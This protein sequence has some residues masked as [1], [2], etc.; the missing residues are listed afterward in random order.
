MKSGVNR[1]KRLCGRILAAAVA[2][3][4]SLAVGC[5]KTYEMDLPLAVTANTLKLTKDAGSTHILI[6]AADKWTATLTDEVKWASINKLSG[7]GNA[8]IV[9]AYAANYGVSR[10]VGVVFTAGGLRDTVMLTQAAAV[11]EPAINFTDRSA[12]LLGA[13]STVRI[14]LTTNVQYNVDDMRVRVT[15]EGEDD[16]EGQS[17]QA[18][19]WISDITFDAESLSL[20]APDYAGDMPRIG[21]VTLSLTDADGESTTTMLTVTQTR[22][23]PQLELSSDAY[24]YD[25]FAQSYAIPAETNLLSYAD[26]IEFTVDYD[27]PV[28]EGEEWVRGLRLTGDGLQFTLAANEEAVRTATLSIAFTDSQGGSVTAEHRITQ[29]IYPKLLAF[30]DLRA[31]IGGASGEAEISVENAIEG[32]V[33]SDPASANVCIS[34][35]TAQFKFDVEESY[36][37]A[38]VE[39]TDGRYGF[40][41]KFASAKDNVLERYSKVR[42]ALK[43][44]TLAKEADPA[45]YTLKGLKAESVIEAAAPDAG[46]LPVKE[47]TIAQLGDDDIFTQVALQDV[48]I[49][50]KDG[51]FTNCTDGYALKT[52]EMNPAGTTTAPRWDCAPLLMTDNTGRAIYMLTN[53]MVPWRRDGRGVPQGA[54]TFNGVVVAEELVRYGD[55]GRYQIRAMTR[56]DIALGDVPA[57]TTLVEWNWSDSKNDVI[58]EVGTGSI[59][60]YDATTALCSDFNAL[61]HYNVPSSPTEVSTDTNAN[62]TGKGLVNNR[63]VYVN[64]RWWDFDANTGRYFDVKFSTAGVSGTNLAIGFAWNHGKMGNTTL[65]SPAHWK[66]L[67]SIDGGETFS[68]F[69]PLVENRSITWWTTTSQDSC[70]GFKDFM[71]PLPAECFGRAEVIVR[72]QVADKVTDIAPG[73]SASTFLQNLGIGRGTLTDKET[74]IRFGALAVRYN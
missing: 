53:S 61:V 54:G 62:N 25:G 9:F 21:Y 72:F 74:Q 51:C 63:A 71:F 47:R 20:S 38:Y 14:P 19:G 31:M 6:Y 59:E 37:T 45:R 23:G 67:Y 40:C 15:Y 11:A 39:S 33:V 30:A 60:L 16:D 52:A 46:Q 18:E 41:L 55:L 58:P 73:T 27:T 64:N 13:A 35:Q 43:G 70:P 56:E 17:A 10:K 4:V 7:E 32:F 2:C 48:E 44:L 66:L 12:T 22:L 42:I 28:A 24:T 50:F 69:V 65:D 26:Q 29:K 1:K 3:L 36:R 5:E 34:P 8:D 57:T 49:A 68:V